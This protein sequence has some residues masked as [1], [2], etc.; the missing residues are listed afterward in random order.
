MSRAHE[1][2]SAPLAPETLALIDA[3]FARVNDALLSRRAKGCEDA[4]ADLRAHV[5]DEL[6]GGAGTPADAERVLAEL[7]APEPL[8]GECAE[9]WSGGGAAKA[10]RL[11]GRV[12]GMPYELRPPTAERVA[13]RW[14]DPMNPHIIVPRLFGLG[15]TVNF[16]ALA[17][18]LG[19]VRPD[20][21]DVPFGEVPGTWLALT[22]A[23]PLALT[24]GLV[25]LIAVYQGGLPDRVA[26]HF[27][28]TGT[29]DGFASKG[30]ALLA[31]LGMT[32]FG[33]A[34][35]LWAWLRRRPP[36][37]RAAAGAL[38]TMLAALSVAVY[39]QEVAAAH[40]VKGVAIL[41]SGIA[42]S[43]VLPF[44]LLVLLSRV[45]RSAEQRR[46]LGPTSKKGSL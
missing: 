18:A 19:L 13:S 26:I 5:F 20:D 9:A 45:G 28:L 30:P 22:L 39:G 7:G 12:L 36:L 27:G 34:L 35:A 3:Y 33:V 43:L 40:D 16:G 29:P 14:W 8:A 31:P 46:D 38:A 23:L 2:L 44:A 32:A 25:V 15:W 4:V 42:V 11:S 10:L 1:G 37:A 41:L 17:V 24:L 21:E 6:A